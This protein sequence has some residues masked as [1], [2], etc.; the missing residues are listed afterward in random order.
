MI[1]E[2]VTPLLP[3]NGV[4]TAPVSVT[5]LCYN[6]P[7]LQGHSLLLSSDSMSCRRLPAPGY[8]VSGALE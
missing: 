6:Q 1:T 4:G 7:G 3:A 5:A 2:G 8:G